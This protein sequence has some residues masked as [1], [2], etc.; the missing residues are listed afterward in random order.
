MCLLLGKE[1]APPESVVTDADIQAFYDLDGNVGKGHCVFAF[2]YEIHGKLWHFQKPVIKGAEVADTTKVPAGLRAYTLEGGKYVRIS[3]TLPN[4]EF[5]WSLE[6][7]AFKEM[8]QETGHQLDL[9]RLFI[10]EQMEYGGSF[11]LYAPV[12]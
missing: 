11:A 7:Y 8:E 9:S 12:K 2:H 3:E 5:D 10:V 4:G 1:E 6:W